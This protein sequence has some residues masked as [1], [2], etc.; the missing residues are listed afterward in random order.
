VIGTSQLYATEATRATGI[1]SVKTNGI[2][3]TIK[4]LT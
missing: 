1:A 3:K 4:D 2:L